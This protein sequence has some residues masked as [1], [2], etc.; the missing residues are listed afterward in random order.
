MKH[1]WQFVLASA[2]LGTALSPALRAQAVHT[3][4]ATALTALAQLAKIRLDKAVD[5]AL[6]ARPGTAVTAE[7][8]GKAPEGTPDGDKSVPVF[9]IMVFGKDGAVYE[10]LVH[11]TDGKVLA[12]AAC[13]DEEDIGEVKA[14]AASK[15]RVTSL[16][17]V[18]AE[19]RALLRGT[20]V[21]AALVA[22][23]H[24]AEVV[25]L[26]RGHRIGAHFRLDDGELIGVTSLDAKAKAGAE[27]EKD[28]KGTEGGEKPAAEKP[29]K[30]AG[31]KK[32]G[33]VRE[34]APKREQDTGSLL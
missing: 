30:K 28:G 25:L 26:N 17:Q 15:A 19:A 16:P 8:E 24:R 21:H 14:M 32:Q 34:E 12:N 7:L 13:E 31:E 23:S 6:E 22:E 3:D 11:A 20:C 27:L 5:I 10:V 18:V 4:K 29:G 33:V 2:L 1:R 9:E